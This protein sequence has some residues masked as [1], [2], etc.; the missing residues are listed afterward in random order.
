MEQGR[1]WVV[2]GGLLLVTGMAGLGYWL[3]IRVERRVTAVAVPSPTATV[4]AAATESPSQA[5]RAPALS[6]PTA[7]P[8]ALAPT[9]VLEDVP[10]AVRLGAPLRIRWQILPAS[11][12]IVRVESTRLFVSL[13]G[14]QE[15]SGPSRSGPS[16]LPARFESV[17][18]LQKRGRAL[19][20]AEAVVAGQTLRTERPVTVE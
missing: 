15:H 7:S 20:T 18:T 19:L 3:G 14:M 5:P 10:R 4:Q 12:S 2:V 6:T 1:V 9:I 11:S 8:N 17:V 13:A 16:A